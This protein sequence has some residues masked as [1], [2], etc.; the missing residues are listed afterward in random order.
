MSR[1]LPARSHDLEECS[2]IVST[3]ERLRKLFEMPK[4]TAR[5]GAKTEP[6]NEALPCRTGVFRQV[7]RD[8][9]IPAA[10][11]VP[12]GLCNVRVDRAAPFGCEVFLTGALPQQR[13]AGWA[14]P[15]TEITIPGKNVLVL[16]RR[17]A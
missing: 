17:D 13:A 5:R 6:R 7:K 12:Q 1:A 16:V 2:R 9:F 11:R 14:S 3:S 15:R 4:R 8:R 10:L